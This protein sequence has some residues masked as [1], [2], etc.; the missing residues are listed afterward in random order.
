MRQLRN[1][2]ILA[3]ET[4]ELVRRW[5]TVAGSRSLVERDSL[6]DEAPAEHKQTAL[7]CALSPSHPVRCLARNASG[8][9]S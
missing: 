4:L 5:W 3:D 9:F 1:S 6:Q 7:R 2:P 8:L